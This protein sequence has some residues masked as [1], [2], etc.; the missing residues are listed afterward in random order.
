[1]DLLTRRLIDLA[2]E[3]DV[4]SSDV[5]SVACVPADANGR[6]TVVAKQPLV[7]AGGEVA[8]EVF[9]RVDA[10]CVV[11]VDAD[12]AA[13]DAGARPMVVEGPLRALLAAERTA[14]NFLMRLCGIATFVRQCNT[15]L[16]GTKTRL[17][18]TRKTTPGLRSLEKAAVRSGGGMN[19]RHAL[20]D[21]FLVK[22]NHAAAAGS[23]GEAV[24][25]C[26]RAAHPLVKVEAEVHTHAQI[27]EALAA[28]ADML[29]LDNLDDAA[30][31]AAVRHVAGRVSTEASGDMTLLRLPRVAK[32]GVD[33]VSMGALTHSAPAA[34]LSLVIDVIFPHLFPS[35]LAGKG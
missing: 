1:M 19:H 30:L 5:T 4:G 7:L 15:A 28:G 21:G 20:F 12:G 23:L 33:F 11:R 18:D 6:A 13:L 31:V 32:T 14:L 22:D 34:D 24:R 26:K 27:D 10:R 8:A 25:R 17:L 3:E 16:A 2:L 9:R 29:L 35:P